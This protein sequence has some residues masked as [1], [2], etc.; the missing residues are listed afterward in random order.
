VLELFSLQSPPK[1][2][3]DAGIHDSLDRQDAVPT[4]LLI[5]SSGGA[6]L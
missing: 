5:A 2:L 1:K 3:Y 4:L 6:C